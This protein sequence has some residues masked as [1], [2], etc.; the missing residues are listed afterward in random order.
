M[1][2]LKPAIGA[3]SEFLAMLRSHAN[4][5]YTNF[6]ILVGCE[7][8]NKDVQHAVQELQHAFPQLQIVL[9]DCPNASEV[10]TARLKYLRSLPVMPGTLSW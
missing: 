6:E 2:I 3:G 7:M 4:Q 10:A 9:V 5:Q 1:S 8:G